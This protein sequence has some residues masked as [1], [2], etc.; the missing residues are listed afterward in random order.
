M[1]DEK[2]ER[3]VER[4]RAMEVRR[5][6]GLTRLWEQRQDLHGVHPS[7]DFAVEAVRWSA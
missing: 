3:E 4:R 2:L 5:T 7:A 1:D 6:E